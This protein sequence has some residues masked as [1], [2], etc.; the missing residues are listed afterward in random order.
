MAGELKQPVRDPVSP[1]V[2][3]KAVWAGANIAGYTMGSVALKELAEVS[4]SAK[5]LRRLTSQV[6][7][8][9]VAERQ[10][11]VAEFAAKTLAE[12]T[13]PKPG[14]EPPDVGVVM[15]DNGTHQRR[16]QF[17]NPEA[18]THWKQETGGVVLSMTSE[19][20]A[21]DPCPDLPA[22]LVHSEMVA[23]ISGLASHQ[24]TLDKAVSDQPAA[25]PEAHQRRGFRGRRRLSPAK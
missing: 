12:R 5:Q 2:L 10:Q 21:D 1:R 25:S 17:K 3:E 4:L 20:H 7:G 11:F 22:W 23:E 19:I 24:D 9:R 15:I 13:T 16:D 6:G 8:D 18:D 14:I